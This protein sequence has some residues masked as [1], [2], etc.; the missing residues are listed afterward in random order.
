MVVLLGANGFVGS[1]FARSFTRRGIPFL[2]V[3]A[4]DYAEHRGVSCDYV[5]HAAGNSR[6]YYA[7]EAPAEEFDLSVRLTLRSIFDFHAA[8]YVLISSVDVYANHSDPDQNR[9]DA[10]DSLLDV[11]NYSFS[12]RMAELCVQRYAPPW[13]IVRLAGMVGPGLRKNPVYDILNRRPLRVDPDSFFQYMST[14]AA[15]EAVWTLV[16]KGLSRQ[17]FNICGSGLISAREIAEE[18]G[19]PL[20]LSLL[21]AGSSPRILNVNTEKVRRYLEVPETRETIRAFV[22]EWK[23]VE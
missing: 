2:P 8:N 6:K 9:E 20:D 1:A 12:K 16:E 3:E 4:Q 17:I 19:K 22:S 14:D 11:S 23:P 21:P 13:L 10:P 18:A 5:V 15:A 7:E